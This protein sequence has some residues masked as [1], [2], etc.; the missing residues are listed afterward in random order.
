MMASRAVPEL[1]GC[2]ERDPTAI[3][4]HFFTHCS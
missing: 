4:K 1:L 2:V 3:Y